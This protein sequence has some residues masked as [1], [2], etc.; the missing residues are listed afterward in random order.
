MM[1]ATKAW[2][3][4]AASCSGYSSGYVEYK[5]NPHDTETR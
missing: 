5:T 3:G 2:R 4:P 1:V